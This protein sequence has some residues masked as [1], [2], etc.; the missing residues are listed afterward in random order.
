MATGMRS[1]DIYGPYKSKIVMAQGKSDINGPHQGAWIETANSED[2]FLHFQDKGLYGRIIHLNPMAWVNDWP[3][4]GN[5]ADGDGCGDAVR[6]WQKPELAPYEPSASASDDDRRL[7]YQWHGNYTDFFGFPIT[8]G[9]MRIY[10]HRTSDAYANLWEVPNLWLQK[11][12]A[13]TFRLTAK[14]IVSA[15]SASEGISSGVVVMGLDYARLGLKKSGDAFIMQFAT[16][17]DADR[18]SQEEIEDLC[19]I[20]PTR[21][22]SAGLH[23][24]MEAEVYFRVD[25]EKDGLCKFYYSLDGRKFFFADQSTARVGK[26]I[27]AKIGFYSITPANTSD[28]GWIDIIDSNIN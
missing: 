22:Y 1:K 3:V 2:W 27:G 19:E 6:S 28:R 18:G 10:G 9:L 7:P 25:V 16:C 21:V 13:E 8:H 20:T 4:I 23:P 17:K 12:P 24:N 15:K 14:T 11:F 5:D 26:W